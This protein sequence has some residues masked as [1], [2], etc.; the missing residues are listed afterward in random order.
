SYGYPYWHFY[1]V[2]TLT[3][4]TRFYISLVNQHW[5]KDIFQGTD[6]SDNEF[7]TVALEVLTS[8]YEPHFLP[9]QISQLLNSNETYT[10]QIKEFANNASSRYSQDE[11]TKAISK[12]LDAIEN[13][14]EELYYELLRMFS[15]FQNRLSQRF[16]N[17]N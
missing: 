12:E 2:M 4:I 7:V 14:N 13:E 6:I 15:S 17:S 1:R 8:T 11:I 9:R 3:P 5:Y 16:I 10:N